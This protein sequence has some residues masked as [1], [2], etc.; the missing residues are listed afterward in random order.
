MLFS[1]VSKTMPYSILGEHRYG[2][3]EHRD[4]GT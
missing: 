1:P 3:G 2:T 4:G